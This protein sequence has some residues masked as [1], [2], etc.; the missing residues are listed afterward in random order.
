[1]LHVELP[2]ASF[3]CSA[4]VLAPLPWHWRAGTVPTIAISLWLFVANII[5]GV[6]SIIW[7]GNVNIVVPV[8]CDICRAQLPIDG[9]CVF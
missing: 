7:A 9:A 2:V 5:A 8:W 6:D 3:I 1:M 4:L